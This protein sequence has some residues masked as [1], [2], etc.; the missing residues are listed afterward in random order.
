MEQRDGE[1]QVINLTFDIFIETCIFQL[2]NLSVTKVIQDFQV[3]DISSC[4]SFDSVMKGNNGKPLGFK[5][6]QITEVIHSNSKNEVNSSLKC[7]DL[8][9]WYYERWI[10]H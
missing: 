2:N 10:L 8:L 5:W 4:V 9:A 3:S 6:R 1:L 7:N